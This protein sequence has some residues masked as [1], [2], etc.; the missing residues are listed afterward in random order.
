MHEAFDEQ[1]VRLLDSR[2]VIQRAQPTRRA[3]KTRPR[4]TMSGDYGHRMT[5]EPQCVIIYTLIFLSE[6][7]RNE[8]TYQCND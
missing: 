5:S 2:Q 1:R 4:T 7:A 3:C 8:Q 6:H